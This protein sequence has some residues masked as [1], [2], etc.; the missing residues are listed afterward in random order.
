MNLSNKT[1]CVAGIG[2]VGGYLG[3]A[4]AKTYPHVTLDRKSVV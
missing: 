1:I 3:A 4:L 2:G